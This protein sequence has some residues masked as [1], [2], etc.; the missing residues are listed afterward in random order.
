M[1][2]PAVTEQRRRV[3]KAGCQLWRDWKWNQGCLEVFPKASTGGMG[4]WRYW[5]E[6]V[7]GGEGFEMM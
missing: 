5:K 4:K 2:D 1:S 7:E 3:C 6:K